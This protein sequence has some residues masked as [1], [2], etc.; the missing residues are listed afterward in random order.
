M[1]EC[2]RQTEDEL[3]LYFRRHL[4]GRRKR[5]RACPPLLQQRGHGPASRRNLACGRTK[6]ACA[7][8]SRSGRVAFLGE[9]SRPGPHHALA[10][11]AEIARAQSG[12]EHLAVHAR[13]L[14]LEPRL[15]TTTSSTI[16]ASPGI[17]SS[18]CPGKSSPSGP[19]TGSTG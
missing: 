5:R 17:S 14:A 3:G 16:A 6:R 10:V 12:R 4:P 18:T 11:A 7:R 9:A 1:D 8:S 13:Q 2:L 15:H 19:E